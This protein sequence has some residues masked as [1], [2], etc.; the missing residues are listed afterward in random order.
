M[1]ARI[2][3]R[4]TIDKSEDVVEHV[5]GARVGDEVE[6][7][8]EH[9]GVVAAVDENAARDHH[10]DATIGT[11]GLCISCRHAVAHLVEGKILCTHVSFACFA[12][13]TIFDE[14]DASCRAWVCLQ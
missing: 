6:S 4:S 11:G 1:C 10:Q 5:V 12:W 2:H 13:L 9:L 14:A 7:L 8:A 3:L